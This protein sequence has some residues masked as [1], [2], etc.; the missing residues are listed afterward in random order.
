MPHNSDEIKPKYTMTIGQLLDALAKLQARYDGNI[1][2]MEI[3]NEYSNIGGF[4]A[5]RGLYC[6]LAIQHD[7]SH[8][9][10]K[11]IFVR[12]LQ[13]IVNRQLSFGGY[14]GGSYTYGYNSLIWTSKDNECRQGYAI[15]GVDVV[16][17][18]QDTCIILRTGHINKKQILAAAPRISEQE[19]VR[20]EN[21]LEELL[22]PTTIM[23]DEP[24]VA[25]PN[26]YKCQLEQC[27]SAI[28]RLIDEIK[29]LKSA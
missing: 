1:M 24:I 3:A 29:R 9:M 22:R 12:R 20:V 4:H 18:K 21:A 15:V 5:Y 25:I 17:K 11:Q 7:S 14:S 13:R 16:G 28:P 10:T 26:R 27:L 6:T 19:I 23:P 8:S 2:R